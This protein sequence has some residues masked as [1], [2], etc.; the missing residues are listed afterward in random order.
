MRDIDVDDAAPAETSDGGADPIQSIFTG[1]LPIHEALRQ[2]RLRL[3]DLSNRNRLISFKH[4]PGKSLRLV[5]TD[6]DKAFDRL[7]EK[8]D[9]LTLSPVPE[10]SQN[11]YVRQGSRDVRPDVRDHALS[12]RINPEFD[13]TAA[14]G[15]F[16]VPSGSEGFALFFPDDLGKH[17]RK[18]EREAKLSLQETGANMLFLVFGF[19]EYVDAKDSSKLLQAPLVAVPVLMERVEQAKFTTFRLVWTGEEITNNLSLVEKL[20]LDHALH[21][22]EF[23][24]EEEDAL[25]RYLDRVEQTIAELPRWRVRRMMTLTLLS[26]T[27]MLMVRDLE[28]DRWPPGASLIDHPIV[29]QIFHGQESEGVSAGEHPIDD[30]PKADLPLIFDADSSQHSALIDVLD[31]QN[32]VIIGPPGTG[33]SQTITNLIA[34]ALQRHKK[35]LFVAEKLAAL[36]VVKTRL[37]QAQLDPFVLELHSNKVDKAQVLGNLAKRMGMKKPWPTDVQERSNLLDQKRK[38]LKAYAE[39]L[40]TVVGNDLE[41]TLHQA[42]WRAERHRLKAA[43][44]ASAVLE[45]DVVNARRLTRLQLETMAEQ[46]RHL[47]SHHEMVGGYDATH[48]FWGSFPRGMGPEDD[49]QIRRVLSTYQRHFQAFDEATQGVAKVLASDGVELPRDRARE[50]AELLSNITPAS[51]EEVD[52]TILPRLFPIQDPDGKISSR[53]LVDFEGRLK[54]YHRLQDKIRNTL[55]KGEVGAPEIG[56][57]AVSLLAEPLAWG[58]GSL[59]QESAAQY[60]RAFNQLAA[61]G[62]TAM[63]AFVEAAGLL[64][65]EFT[66]APEQIDALLAIAR[67]C[68]ACD[69]I[70]LNRRHDRLKTVD[71]VP[72]LSRL[73]A[74]QQALESLRTSLAD[75]L[76]LDVVVADTVLFGAIQT[77]REGPTWYRIFQSRWRVAISLHRGL[78]KDKIKKPPAVRLAE[79]EQLRNHRSR[80]VEWENDPVFAT[81]AGPHFLGPKTELDELIRAAQWIRQACDDL[82]QAAVTEAHFDPVAADRLL[83]GKLARLATRMEADHLKLRQLD[84]AL[85]RLF[86][87]TNNSRPLLREVTQWP[88]RCDLLDR[89]SRSL[90]KVA[91]FMREHV[92]AHQTL[93]GANSCLSQCIDLPRIREQLLEHREAQALLEHRF[94]GERTQLDPVLGALHLGRSI[95]NAKLPGDV[96]RALISERCA[97]HHKALWEHTRAIHQGWIHAEAFAEEMRAFGRFEPRSWAD[98]QDTSVREYSQQLARRTLVALDNL[99]SLLPWSQYVKARANVVE[100]GLEPFVLALEAKKISPEH[101]ESAYRYRVFASIVKGVFNSVPSL[102]AFSGEHHSTV[103]RE[104]VKLD[105]EIIKGRGE[106][107]ARTSMSLAMPPLGENGIKVGD[108]TQMRLLEYLITK[109]RPRMSLRDI[110]RRAGEAIQQIKP[111]FMM[112]PQAVAQYL[113]P[114]G[115]KFDIVVMD[116]ASQLRP[117]QAIG[118]VARGGQLVVVGDPKQLPPTAFFTNLAAADAESD[119][120][121]LAQM[122]TSDAES[123]LDVCISHFQPVRT[124]RWHY[125]SRHES[126]I[127]FSNQEFYNSDLVVFPSPYPKGRALGLSYHY[128]AGAEYENQM[129]LLEARRIVDAAVDHILTRPEDS[130]GLVTLNI[131]Q[132]DLVAELLEAR[133]KDLPPAQEWLAQWE[134]R[135]NGL[136]V[137]NLENV[138][139]DERDCILISTTF[140]RAKGTSVVRQN[141]GPISRSGGWRRL[142]VLFTRAR[143]SVKVFS[144]MKPEEIVSDAR[145]PE[146]T[147]ALR[148]YLEFAQSGILRKEKETELPPDSDFEIAVMDVLRQRGY[149][150]TPQLGVAGFR[151]DIAVKHPLCLSGYLAA[152]ECDGA[153]YHSGVSVRDRDRIRQEIL[154]SLG[155]KGRIWRIWSTDWFRSPI[156]ETEKLIRFLD[157]LKSQPLTAEYLLPVVEPEPEEVPVPVAPAAA[158]QE[159]ADTLV[160]DHDEDE[161]EIQVGD[162]VSYVAKDKPDEVITMRLTSNQTNLALGLIGANTPLGTA[163]LDAVPGDEVV[164]RIP[165]QLGKAYV[166]KEVRRGA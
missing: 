44:S 50:L 119:G 72:Q 85:D 9:K 38:H 56:H 148:N 135:G 24:G 102:K 145:T 4:T 152:I 110:M 81:L 120:D 103:R 77:L 52:Y 136:F 27:N 37:T 165:G 64:Q 65:Q 6:F 88:Q 166:V 49:V 30:N 147:R 35:V 91:D 42:M 154:E 127:A 48:P 93:E 133:L 41:L 146:G 55:F 33:K 116:E 32:R 21:L 150:V 137:K 10:P 51:A 74:E 134:V 94:L 97:V 57:H 7:F 17:C 45:V 158:A 14:D 67:V 123:I 124:L 3:L 79:L 117:E 54:A 5:H 96:E 104:Y 2:L 99:T 43:H 78:A 16:K 139:G 68:A 66:G 60:A 161:L 69:P 8:Q 92:L 108:K 112:G 163:F 22:P 125:R 59:T 155:W 113:S 101:L 11:D 29:K 122:A 105:V 153:S 128:V 151:I 25:T 20:R 13:L 15:R 62:R 76:Y 149:E 12:R 53:V 19:L 130:L 109:Q 118:A 63:G 86:P 36:E 142:N 160:L 159:A 46:L 131:K 129:N 58:L 107:I 111:C 141:F 28:P 34:A 157:Y 143:K 1:D 47:A 95:R 140:G 98:Y 23:D 82:E 162:Q 31:G 75:V 26:F 80:A 83:V 138:Q 90:V 126:L 71:A 84:R 70:A 61:E 39:L 89:M 73:R 87:A 144:S 100:E 164:L 115:L 114:G 18:L 40:N 156:A 121:A 106:D 132:R